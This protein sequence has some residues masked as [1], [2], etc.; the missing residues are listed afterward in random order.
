MSAEPFQKN[1]FRNKTLKMIIPISISP[2]KTF[3]P[4]KCKLTTV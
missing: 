4:K 2:R 1:N 3:S